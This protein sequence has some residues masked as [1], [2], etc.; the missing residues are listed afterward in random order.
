MET[1]GIKNRSGISKTISEAE[2]EEIF[3]A[4]DSDRSGRVNYIEWI[5]SMDPETLA[6]GKHLSG[7]QKTEE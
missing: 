7:F 6:M 2:V 5:D 3:Q 4:L 1:N